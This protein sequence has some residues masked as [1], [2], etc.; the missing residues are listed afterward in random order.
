MFPTMV[1]DSNDPNRRYTARGTGEGWPTALR[2][3]FWLIMVAALL[4]LLNGMML[5]ATGFPDGADEQ[6]R[7]AFML[8][9][10]VT[11]FGNMLLAIPLV[12]IATELPRATKQ[13]RIW[14][15]ALIAAAIFLNVV[16]FMI[17]VASWASFSIV[18]LLT[19]AVF[20]LFRPAANQFVE[21]T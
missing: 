4:M 15:A 8:N 16:A 19:F 5:L 9:M 14:A 6:F 3:S 1:G 2:T 18:L 11:A 20:F 13:V 21:R 7:E 10:R 12:V 17:K